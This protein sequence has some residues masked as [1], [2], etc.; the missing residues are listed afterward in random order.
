M[1]RLNFKNYDTDV[2][3]VSVIESKGLEYPEAPKGGREMTAIEGYTHAEYMVPEVAMVVPE[4]FMGEAPKS[5]EDEDSEPLWGGDVTLKKNY[6]LSAPVV[7]TEGQSCTV[8]LN[9]KALTA[10]VFTESN[11]E[12]IEGNSDSYVF[13]TKGGELIIDGD[14]RVEA[15]EAQYSMAVWAQG[16]K[17]TINGG[18]FYNHGDGCDLIYASNGGQVEIHGGEFHATERSGEVP[19]TKN[20]FSALNIKDADRGTASIVVYGGKF[21][22]FDPANNVSEGPDTNFV[23]DGYKSVEVE[24]G[25]W[26]VMPE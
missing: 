20:R 22:G 9:G 14:G 10:P 11:G 8:K 24:T 19:G 25:V 3:F 17:V 13:W 1:D 15:Q 16:G 21:F 23:A 5:E 2:R 12:V 18:E 26:E 6:S 7:L 4:M